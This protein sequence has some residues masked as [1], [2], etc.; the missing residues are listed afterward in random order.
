M[1]RAFP[2]SQMFIQKVFSFFKQ[3]FQINEERCQ[4]CFSPCTP[5]P[6]QPLL[7]ETCRSLL[8]P[9]TA[10]RCPSCG[11]PLEAQ[12]G[13]CTPCQECL[14]TPPPWSDFACYGLYQGMLKEI[15]LRHKFHEELH[16]TRLLATFLHT[17]M[18]S[19]PPCD[20]IVCIPQYHTHLRQRGFNQAQ[21]LTRYLAQMTDMPPYHHLLVRSQNV[22]S[23][24]G[25][26][27]KE[28][29]RNPQHT[30]SCPSPEK[31]TQR[32]IL[33]VDDIFTTGA[34]LRHA[35]QTLLENGAATV[36]ILCVARTPH[37][38]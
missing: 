37:F 32:N 1:T 27:R 18:A 12:D 30:F 38:L 24:V 9:F 8:T 31:L 20:C 10:A 33:L 17:A 28:R 19:L 21:E 26:S 2:F 29:L 22:P 34:T 15:L 23:Q 16:L 35:S 5:Q 13:P 3:A 36:R 14:E 6:A 25:L 11:L 4:C 7:C